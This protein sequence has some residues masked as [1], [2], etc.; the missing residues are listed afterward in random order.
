MEE[1]HRD[2]A[3][4]RRLQGLGEARRLLA[5]RRCEECISLLTQLQKEFPADPDIAK[6]LEAARDVE[7]SQ[8]RQQHVGKARKLLAARR[9]E[10]C[11]LLLTDLRT[12][13]PQDGE[14]ANL[15]SA[16]RDEE[17]EQRKLHELAEARNL[18]AVR[19]YDESI[20]L[21][22][23]LQ[24]EYP[25]DEE[26]ARLMSTVQ[27]DQAEQH[28]LQ[29]LTEARNLLAQRR[30]D[31]CINLATELQKTF[32]EE[33]E[34]TR[35]LETASREQAEQQRQ[36]KLAEARGFLA[37]GR[38]MDAQ[39]LLESLQSVDPPDPSVLKLLALVQGEQEKQGKAERLMREWK[40]LKELVDEKKYPEVIARAEKLLID[41]PNDA[42]LARLVDFS[43]T[44]QTQL[45][46]E[47]LLGQACE[48][49]KALSAA[50][51][52][53]D[54]LQAAQE[55]LKAFPDNP[56]LLLLHEQAELQN[57]KFQTRKAIEQRI[58]DIK[59]KINREKFSEAIELAKQ[60]LVSL[61]P[62]SGV[63][64][65]LSSAKVEFE[66]RQNRREQEKELS[67][68][69]TLVE[70]GKLDEAEQALKTAVETKVLE[71]FDPRVERV[72]NDIN[73][74]KSRSSAPPTPG[75]EPKPPEPGFSKEYAWQV[76]TPSIAPQ[77]G[78]TVQAK[79]APE[80][81]SAQPP[82]I[83]APPPA[84]A[85]TIVKV[86]AP[87][88][89]KAA[90]PGI[91]TPPAGTTP[92]KV[93][94]KRIPP[95]SI[96]HGSDCHWKSSTTAFCPFSD[97]SC[98]LAERG[99]NSALASTRSACHRWA[100][101]WRLLIWGGVHFLSVTPAKPGASGLRRQNIR[102]GSPKPVRKTC[103]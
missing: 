43:R 89:G 11:N 102:P 15:I 95:P 18:L 2:Q 7:V 51:R 87:S 77:P 3:N 92:R 96:P 36:A 64:Q 42:D 46:R 44:Q 103:S 67:D 97:R 79:I 56:E 84:M 8:R 83:S 88:E 17:L 58:R 9:Y 10:E 30:Y 90:K 76:W 48:K 85:P 81:A 99:R 59:V 45:D 91:V 5:G 60:T 35:L 1:V 32:P 27:S 4:Q 62:D 49:I 13:F 82:A 55:A 39:A 75:P 78:E 28:K 72:S 86:P 61:G 22:A 70:S 25:E 37:A 19:H 65:L 101:C 74:A 50:N 24:Q 34:I 71:N 16:V 66:A 23:K 12:Q 80:Q 98:C 93:S 52:F 41:F 21:L 69:R 54:A 33:R 57:R 40:V 94:S 53:Q 31:E 73:A 29:V 38:L 26:V 68:I 100:L 6:L 63:T 20:A 14:I 47:L